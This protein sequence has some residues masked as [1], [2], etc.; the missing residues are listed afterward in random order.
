VAFSA[1]PTCL[2]GVACDRRQGD[3]PATGAAL[4]RCVIRAGGHRTLSGWIGCGGVV[5]ASVASGAAFRVAQCRAA[6]VAR[7]VSGRTVLPVFPTI[8]MDR[9]GGQSRPQPPFQAASSGQAASQPTAPP[10]GG[11][12]AKSSEYAAAD[13]TPHAELGT[14]TLRVTEPFWAKSPNSAGG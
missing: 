3:E 8:L 10:G 11:C 7:G 14:G 2:A 12:T 9:G 13:G 6:T 5:G 1:S 4:P